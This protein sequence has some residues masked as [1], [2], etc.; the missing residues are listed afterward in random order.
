MRLVSEIPFQNPLEGG[1]QFNAGVL[2]Q[3]ASSNHT[4]LITKSALLLRKNALCLSQSAF[5]NFVLHVITKV[6]MS[7]LQTAEIADQ[8]DG[9][10]G[11]TNRGNDALVFSCTNNQGGQK[12]SKKATPDEVRIKQPETS[13][14]FGSFYDCFY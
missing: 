3:S 14:N 6:N 1:N 2:S 7:P 5:S 10:V 11:K 9:N 4:L 8:N 13:S 12:K